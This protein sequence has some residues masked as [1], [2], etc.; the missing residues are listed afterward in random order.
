MRSL[1]EIKKANEEAVA[2]LA[3]DEVGEWPVEV[4]PITDEE[5]VDWKRKHLARWQEV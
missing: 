5:C 1:E 3:T 2:D 4:K